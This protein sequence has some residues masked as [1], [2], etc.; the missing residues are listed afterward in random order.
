M[1]RATTYQHKKK[2]SFDQALSQALRS[3]KIGTGN[4]RPFSGLFFGAHP[5]RRGLF[6]ARR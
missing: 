3:V 2:Q 4:R 5:Y 6:S 1:A